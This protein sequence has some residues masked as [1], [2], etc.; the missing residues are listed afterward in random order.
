MYHR[1]RRMGSRRRGVRQAEARA[2]SRRTGG[3]SDLEDRERIA[4]PYKDHIDKVP[5]GEEGGDLR[6]RWVK[7]IQGD[8]CKSWELVEAQEQPERVRGYESCTNVEQKPARCR[9]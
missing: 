2:R 4:G 8:L 6:T 3:S 9:R 7:G 5:R 1:P